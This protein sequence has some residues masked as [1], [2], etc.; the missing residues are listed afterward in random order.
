MGFAE[1]FG[2]YLKG[3]IGITII[4]NDSGKC[5]IANDCKLDVSI[6]NVFEST[7]LENPCIVMEIAYH[8]YQQPIYL[9]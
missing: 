4:M 7:L 5:N 1:H 3:T 6:C 8:Q 9:E 2:Q